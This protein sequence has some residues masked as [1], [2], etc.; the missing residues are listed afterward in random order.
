MTHSITDNDSIEIIDADDSCRDLTSATPE[1]RFT[2]GIDL[3]EH[4]GIWA[5]ESDDEDDHPGRTDAIA[6]RESMGIVRVID[7]YRDLPRATPE[8]RRTIRGFDL[9]KILGICA[10]ELDD[11]FLEEVMVPS[12]VNAAREKRS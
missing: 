2:R 12:S 11:E 10:D 4:F 8:E 1:E 9:E 3:T 6:A 5:D 7:P